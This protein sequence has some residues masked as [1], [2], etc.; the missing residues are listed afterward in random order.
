[1][2]NKTLRNTPKTVP[3]GMTMYQRT[4]LNSYII[5]LSME[6]TLLLLDSSL[7]Q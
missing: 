6:A 1:M 2:H 7:K 4:D 3:T 5:F